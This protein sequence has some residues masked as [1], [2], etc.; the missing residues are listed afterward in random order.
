MTAILA[1]QLWDINFLFARYLF[2][3]KIEKKHIQIISK[4]KDI[5]N[6]SFP[7]DLLSKSTLYE[8]V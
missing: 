6:E 4:V 7:F 1:Y 5:A 8:I 2:S 3:Y